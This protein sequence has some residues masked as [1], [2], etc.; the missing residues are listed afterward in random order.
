MVARNK[1]AEMVVDA[2][3]SYQ[4]DWELFQ[5]GIRFRLSKKQL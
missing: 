5:P 2:S 1:A 4:N 3:I